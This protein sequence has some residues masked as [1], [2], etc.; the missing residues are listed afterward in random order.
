[1]EKAFWVEA[2]NWDETEE[3]LTAS[4]M[5]PSDYLMWQFDRRNA[6]DVVLNRLGQQETYV[7]VRH[8]DHWH[9]VGDDF[10]GE[11]SYKPSDGVLQPIDLHQLTPLLG[12]PT[13][14]DMV[15]R[16]VLESRLV[17]DGHNPYHARW[18][19]EEGVPK[20]GFKWCNDSYGTAMI[21][22]LEDYGWST[23][24]RDLAEE[25]GRQKLG[26]PKSWDRTESIAHLRDTTPSLDG[27]GEDGDF[28]W[29]R[30]LYYL[31]PVESRMM[32]A[33]W[34]S[35]DHSL[36]L[37]ELVGRVW[38]SRPASVDE[39][40]LKRVRSYA[41]RITGALMLPGIAVSVRPDGLTGRWRVVV[42]SE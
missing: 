9:V 27:P 18:A 21:R 37:E 33:L 32:S 12:D 25:I 20:L 13:A 35:A 19:V 5:S 31:D 3:L 38:E 4:G 28:W 1:M 26:F 8:A 34:E 10:A 24:A 7:S 6:L 42:E 15:A 2:R 23:I 29:H 17:C 16:G 11:W 40:L 22:D 41:S 39:Q 14:L 36:L 30:V